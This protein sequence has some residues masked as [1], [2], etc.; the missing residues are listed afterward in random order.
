M[1]RKPIRVAGLLDSIKQQLAAS[2]TPLSSRRLLANGGFADDQQP[3][4]SSFL[5]Q[6]KKQGLVTVDFGFDPD[7][8]KTDRVYAATQKLCDMYPQHRTQDAQ[9]GDGVLS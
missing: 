7:Y 9:V 1:T 8:P 3:H 4:V 6:L 2:R 5:F